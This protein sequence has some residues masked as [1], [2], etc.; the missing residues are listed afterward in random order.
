[1]AEVKRACAL[2]TT[3]VV[4]FTLINNNPLND[5]QHIKQILP[6]IILHVLERD[7]LHNTLPL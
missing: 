1:M 3:M 5:H 7:L 4:L 2:I 6:G